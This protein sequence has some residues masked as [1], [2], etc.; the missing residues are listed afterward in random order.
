MNGTSE[1]VDSFLG[2]LGI[3]L[4]AT[5]EDVSAVTLKQLGVTLAVGCVVLVVTVL[6][7][8]GALR[9]RI[10]H[11]AP[12]CEARPRNVIFNDAASHPDQNRGNPFLLGWV[13]WSFSLSYHTMMMGV[14]GTGTR[15]DGLA[16]S[17]LKVNLDNIVL[18]RF[19]ALAL[20]IAFFAMCTYCGIVL[21]VYMTTTCDAAATATTAD[22]VIIQNCTSDTGYNV[23][24][25]YEQ[26]TL[27]NV[28]SL[29]HVQGWD[30]SEALV[31]LRLYI[32][33]LCT[34]VV[35]WYTC[36]ELQKEWIDLL[37][38]RRVYYLEYD[39]WK[40]RREE[41]QAIMSQRDADSLR[42]A[43]ANNNKKNKRVEDSTNPHLS[44]REAWIPHPGSL[45]DE[46]CGIVTSGVGFLV[47]LVLI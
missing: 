37:A 14:P 23:T 13:W 18:L 6:L 16:G 47:F 7:F 19:H 8:A 9:L 26:M 24:T 21:P 36:Y 40:G 29:G 1:Y 43:S 11:I 4:E 32:V 28:P 34:Y 39:H 5:V 2:P 27:A 46:L 38:L 22:G 42:N 10:T 25:R 45:D 15:H 12:R 44:R 35:C 20:R 33:V 3:T 30:S 31:M 17:M 41:L